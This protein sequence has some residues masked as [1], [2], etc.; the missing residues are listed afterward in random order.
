M[1][2]SIEGRFA[3]EIF[4]AKVT[5]TDKLVGSG[6]CV[7]GQLISLILLGLQVLEAGLNSFAFTFAVI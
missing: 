2:L 5:L 1:Q 3:N 7:E 4:K 6:I